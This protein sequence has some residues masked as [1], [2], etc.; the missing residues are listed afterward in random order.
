MNEKELKQYYKEGHYKTSGAPSNLRNINSVKMIDIS[1]DDLK[2]IAQGNLTLYDTIIN[3]HNDDELVMVRTNKRCHPNI[4]D[5]K[6]KYRV[7]KFLDV[8][9]DEAPISISLM[10]RAKRLKN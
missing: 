9:E 1:E 8:Y 7:V 2:S 3:D 10:H 5:N 6:K 4:D